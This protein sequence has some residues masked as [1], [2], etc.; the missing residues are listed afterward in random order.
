M[1]LSDKILSIVIYIQYLFIFVKFKITTWGHE[2]SE[3]T[4]LIINWKGPYSYDDITNNPELR[5]GLYLAA[6]KQKYERGDN[7]IQYCGITEGNFSSRFRNHHKLPLITREQEFWLGTVAVPANASRY[8][9]E[10]AE[11]LIIYFWQPSLNEKK[12]ISPPKSTTV[13]NYWF[14]KDGQPRFNQ[15]AIYRDLPDV[16]SWDTEH[17]RTGN[18]TVYTDY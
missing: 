16:L 1:K 13:I 15:R 9:L 5:N 10:M 18:L 6:G 12:K 2:I 3:H 17:W 7:S 11:A 4:T 8:Y 14:T